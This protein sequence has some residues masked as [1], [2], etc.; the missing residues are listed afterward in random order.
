MQVL[1]VI[2][3]FSDR[4]QENGCEDHSSSIKHGLIWMKLVMFRQIS[5]IQHVKLS[6]FLANE[7]PVG[8]L[9]GNSSSKRYS[10]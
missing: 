7:Q 2:P 1:T 5:M 9:L 6:I 3:A 8:W 10:G 4:C